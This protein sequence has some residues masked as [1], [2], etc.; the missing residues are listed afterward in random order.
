MNNN[1]TKTSEAISAHDI[2]EKYKD[3]FN[4]AAQTAF[5]EPQTHSMV[6]QRPGTMDEDVVVFFTVRVKGEHNISKAVDKIA[7]IVNKHASLNHIVC[8]LT[9][10]SYI[11]LISIVPQLTGPKEY[12]VFSF[13][14]VTPEGY[15]SIKANN[16]DIYEEEGCISRCTISD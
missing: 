9:R 6:R 14:M 2:Y 8:P 4:L 16:Y 13:P 7:E 15:A 12:T 5:N 1:V 11:E 3:R 10:L